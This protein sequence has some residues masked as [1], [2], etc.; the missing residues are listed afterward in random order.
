MSRKKTFRTL[1]GFVFIA[2][3]TSLSS[4]SLAQEGKWTIKS[5]I[6][7]AKYG[8][9]TSE[10][11]GK[12]Y[13]VG[14]R[15]G[16]QFFSTM[17]EYDPATDTWTR[18][19]D[20]PT[21]RNS[22]STSVVNGKIYAIAGVE[23]G[24]IGPTAKVEEYDPAMDTWRRRAD[25]PATRRQF[26]TS[27]VNGK[28]YA[29]GGYH[30]GGSGLG[31]STV[32]EYDPATNTWRARADMPTGRPGLSTSVVDGKIY[33]IGGN[34][35]D[36][37]TATATHFST[38]EEY[39]PATD[40][41]T[42]R[43]DMP[44][45]RSGLS[46]SVVNGKIYAIGG[47]SNEV[48][49][50]STVEV[51]DP[52]TDTW[53]PKA[54]M[55]PTARFN[56][57]TSVVNGRI[58]AIGGQPGP[59][60][61]VTSAVEAYQPA[62]WGFAHGPNPADGSL[63]P[64]TWVNLFWGPG[65][66][67]VSHD[68][69][70]GDS[71]DA[72]NDGLGDTFRGNQTSML[73]SAGF[74][75]SPYPDGLVRGT[76][77]YWRVDEVNDT[78]PDSP[79]K[80]SVWSFT[81]Q[82]KIAYNP[83]PPDGTEFIDLDV[84]LSWTAGLDA[85]LH[86]V[87][88][89]DNFDDVNDATGGLKQVATTYTPRPLEFGKTYYW[90]V[91]ELGGGR[92]GGMHKGEIWSFITQG[93]A[94]SPDP[95]N[96]ATSVEMNAI[97]R[98]APADHA[99]SHQVYFGTDKEAVRNANTVSPEYK[100]TQTLGAENLDPGVLS[101]DT[102]YYWRVDEVNN[103]HPDSPW[104]GSVWSFMTGDFFIIDDFEDYNIGS[105]EIW[106]SWKD[107]TGYANHPTEPLYAGNGTG[108]RVGDE[109]T[110]STAYEDRPLGGRQSMPYWYDNNK[111]GFL[112]YSEAT[113]TLTYLRDWTENGVGTL[114]IWSGA[115]GDWI[116]NTSLNDDEPM[117]VVLNGSAVVYHNDPDITAIYN[118][119]EWRI[120]LQEFADL[121]VDLTDIHTIGLGFGDRDNPQPG[122]SGKMYFDDIRLY[123]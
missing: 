2:F 16:M 5:D 81:V 6:P 112:K 95:S 100:G 89:G 87:Y 65:D 84:E 72:V 86:T 49:C 32:E 29:I 90:R 106:W 118:W 44:T 96:D 13:A 117:Y 42:T 122:G 33:A 99:A 93:A 94:G 92:G 56:F 27:V 14:G 18:K 121:G 37:T 30:R 70:L 26:S 82:P 102:T 12:I 31:E 47:Q 15:A 61:E 75:G 53:T 111:T 98:W 17:E 54:D 24:D 23:G 62:P 51:Y 25:M 76:T 71:F 10:V 97:L 9:S 77:Y 21:A 20:M 28:I 38:V 113:L 41:W 120:D 36:Y 55:M 22:L 67:A 115:D 80:G 40:T 3:L 60:P 101:W 91:D 63:H 85:A 46:S 110:G 73:I 50:L 114:S 119:T 108:S 8:L 57:S 52:V 43:T 103:T 79:W 105:N 48:F 107:G 116:T 11:N 39:D 68:V 88:L 4:V 69:Y 104:A 34:K 58:Y 19:A 66:F 1:A 45:A 74:P 7:T 59:W 78:E 83:I 35:W 123:R 109:F 64:D